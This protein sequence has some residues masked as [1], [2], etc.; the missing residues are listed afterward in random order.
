M[1]ELLENLYK[2]SPKLTQ[3]YIRD[4]LKLTDHRA[5]LVANITGGISLPETELLCKLVAQQ[6]PEISLEVGLGY[7]FS[8]LAICSSTPANEQRTHI[9]IDPYQEKFWKNLGLR[10]LNE[11]G[12]S[13]IVDFYPQKSYQALPQLLQDG[14]RVD[15]AFIDGWHTF[16]YVLVD[17]FY[18]DKILKNGGVVA[19][20]DADWKSIRPLIRYIV[21]NLN[22]KVVGTLPE[23]HKRELID[24]ELGIEGSCIALQKISDKDN[25][26]IFFHKAFF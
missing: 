20:D 2:N 4:V 7:G 15:F 3:E 13:D 18:I 25:R 14:V 12:Y 24:I 5:E 26:E 21:T 10:H 11:A 6:R 8:A 1:N 23:K 22:Y 17:F 9:V 19:F 16:D